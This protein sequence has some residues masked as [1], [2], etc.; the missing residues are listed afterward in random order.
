MSLHR[1]LLTLFLC[2][3]P[4]FLT[5]LSYGE[6]STAFPKTISIG[7]SGA[8]YFSMFIPSHP[9][10]GNWQ[11][12][13]GAVYNTNESAA[14]LLKLDSEG[15]TVY[16]NQVTIFG[17]FS[18]LYT[19][20]DSSKLISTHFDYQSPSNLTFGMHSLD[21]N[22]GPIFETNFFGN[23]N[24]V[25]AFHNGNDSI[26]VLEN[27]TR[28]KYV[29]SSFAETGQLDWSKSLT[30]DFFQD[31][32]GLKGIT[33]YPLWNPADNGYF[34]GIT[35]SLNTE[36]GFQRSILIT[37]I[38]NTGEI[39]WSKSTT[40]ETSDGLPQIVVFPNDQAY[41]WRSYS[42]SEQTNATDIAKLDT[43]GNQ[44]WSKRILGASFRPTQLLENGHLILKSNSD[45]LHSNTT[46]LI[47]L[48][49]LGEIKAKA[50]IT[51]ATQ[52]SVDRIMENGDHLWVVMNTFSELQGVETPPSFSTI[53][54]LNSS[55]LSN[56]QW[57]EYA[58]QTR[59]GTLATDP[60][61]GNVLFAAILRGE[62]KIDA[63]LLDPEFSNDSSAQSLRDADVTIGPS[64]AS[65]ENLNWPL[66]DTA[67]EFINNIPDT[68]EGSITFSL[69]QLS[70]T[71]VR[72]DIA[73]TTF[74]GETATIN[75]MSNEQVML[76]FPT[77]SGQEYQIDQKG[78]LTN[79]EWTNPEVIQGTGHVTGKIYNTVDGSLFLR[80]QASGE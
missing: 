51:Y 25:R 22:T 33:A 16:K 50:S 58:R 37:R 56:S 1:N 18:K 63:I 47:V 7:P 80:V 78:D 23:S 57:F 73:A 45:R 32:S 74:K 75:A 14:I 66:V 20:S 15:N 2:S 17:G 42:T 71:S 79:T 21:E 46:E 44:I 67:V 41:A 49:S 34:F 62:S 68:T 4:L 52:H 64:T 76:L 26:I 31:L 70:E 69:P 11:L 39:L 12:E 28:E 40:A 24:F 54:R 6:D 10:D 48:D 55:D 53:G 43:D 5:S 61:T 27:Y 38:S 72:V 65:I 35:K 59:S 19:N 3:G 77:E 60:E 36:L 13:L 9:I 30:S 8:Q 29:V